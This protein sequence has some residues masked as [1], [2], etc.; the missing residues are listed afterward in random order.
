MM[1]RNKRLND[2]QGK[3]SIMIPI[4][5]HNLVCSIVG[6]IALFLCGTATI[7]DGL[8]L[9]FLLPLSFIISSLV[10]SRAFSYW[11]DNMAFVIIFVTILVR[12]LVTPVLMTLSNTAL[13][14]VNPSPG[15][16]RL[17][18]IIQIFELFSTLAVIDY[19]WTRHKR[20]NEYVEKDESTHNIDFKLTWLGLIFVVAL[21]GLLVVRGHLTDLINRY[22]TW[23][24]ISNDFS[25]VYFYDYIAVEVVK[26]VLGIVLISF[27]AKNFHRSTSLFNK[28]IFYILAAAVSVCMTMI[29]LYDQRTA[30][31][32][33]VISSMVLLMAFFPSKRLFSLVI[34]GIGGGFLVTYVFATGSMGYESGSVNGDILTELSKMAELYVSGPSMVAITQQKY[35]WVRDNMSAATYLS[36]LI[37]TS[38]IFGMFPFLRGVLNLVAYIPTSNIL[39]VESLGGLTYILPNYSLWTYY[40]SE[41]FGWLFEIF[42]IYLVIRAI[43]YVDTK[44]KSSGDAFIYYALAYVETL[45]GQAIFVNNTFLLWHAFTNLPLWLLVF[46][47]INKLGNKFSVFK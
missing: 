17:A 38:H 47:Y 44:K 15:Y 2:I 1:W 33:L 28:T 16:Y 26:A 31:V 43:C 4:G 5:M 42:S 40:V 46:A 35:N 18:I 37:T 21:L 30:L 32:Q 45:L 9:L 10:F 11:R 34:F 14:T 39:F 8:E 25:A 6:F 3:K 12:Y 13:T 41:F 24:H 23:W 22:S 27:F 29:Y 19:V 7:K 36:D 20:K